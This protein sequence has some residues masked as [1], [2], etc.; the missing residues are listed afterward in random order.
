MMNFVAFCSLDSSTYCKFRLTVK[1]L[2]KNVSLTKTKILQVIEFLR[3]TIFIKF[4][5]IF[6]VIG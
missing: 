4:W 2:P 6:K 5:P 1:K 3:F